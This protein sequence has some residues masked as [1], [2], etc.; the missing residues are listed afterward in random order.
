[1]AGI[2]RCTLI[3]SEN[4]RDIGRNKKL[5]CFVQL[6]L[7]TG[8]QCHMAE[9]FKKTLN[10][11]VPLQLNAYNC[12]TPN[13]LASM[14]S[15]S[16]IQLIYFWKTKQKVMYTVRQFGK[17]S[18]FRLIYLT[19]LKDNKVTLGYFFDVFLLLC[20]CCSLRFNRF[21]WRTSLFHIS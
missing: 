10:S 2:Y 17:T 19:I 11:E 15:V 13:F 14:H 16:P 7:V 20:L 1:M 21:I 9:K 8:S 12:K 18:F 3:C 5:K 6:P 4:T